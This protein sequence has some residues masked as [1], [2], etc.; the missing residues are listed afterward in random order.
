MARWLPAPK[1][2]ASQDG[3][4]AGDATPARQPYPGSWFELDPVAAANAW[5][6]QSAADWEIDRAVRVLVATDHEAAEEWIARLPDGKAKRKGEQA[7]LSRRA[8]EDPEA[9]LGELLG[10][11]D[12]QAGTSP[13]GVDACLARIQARGGDWQAWLD[14]LPEVYRRSYTVHRLNSRAALL[15]KLRNGTR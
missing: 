8:S 1:P 6:G 13:V 5:S 3:E 15:E 14:R 11:A 9:V 4:T 7:L 10:S 2:N 12:F